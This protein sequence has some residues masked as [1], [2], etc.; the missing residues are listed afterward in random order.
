MGPFTATSSGYSDI[1]LWNY[2]R[3]QD[4]DGLQTDKTTAQGLRIPTNLTP[5]ETSTETLAT[6]TMMAT[7]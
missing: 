7:R 5:T 1:A 2:A 6:M 3:D 4:S